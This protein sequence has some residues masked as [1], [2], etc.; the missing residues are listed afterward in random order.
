MGNRPK[1]SVG[2]L[3]AQRQRLTKE[4][5][6][7]EARAAKMRPWV[8]PLE[9]AGNQLGHALERV[10]DLLRSARRSRVEVVLEAERAGADPG[11]WA[12]RDAHNTMSTAINDFLSAVESMKAVDESRDPEG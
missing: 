1:P 8:G 3:R 2:E 11:E 10:D 6:E 9:R 12:L 4:V 5:A 7:L